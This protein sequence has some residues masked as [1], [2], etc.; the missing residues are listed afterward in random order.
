MKSNKDKLYSALVWIISGTALI[1]YGALGLTKTN[2]PGV[3]QL[4]ALISNAEGSFLFIAAFLAI[5]VEGL[6]VIGSFFPGSTLVLFIAIFAQVGGAW[7]FAGTILMIYL[8]WLLA[9]IVNIL[10]ARY[11]SRSF[12]DKIEDLKPIE[13]NTGLTWFPAF[14][15]NTEVAQITEGHS[16]SSVFWSTWRVKTI[17][18]LGAAVYAFIVPM[19]IDFQ[20]ISNEEGFWSLSVIA[21]INFA[22]GG[23]KL[24][25]YKKGQ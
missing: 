4:V 1:T 14:R 2:I 21:M 5:L 15:A 10:G 17:A 12:L 13:D 16:M 3:E 8:G 24:R 20:D 25:Q 18:S 19:F 22:V 9:G 7:Q 6:Y 11:F 23:Y